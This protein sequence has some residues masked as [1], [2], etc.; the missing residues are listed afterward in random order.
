ME[1]TIC[2]AIPGWENKGYKYLAPG[3]GRWTFHNIKIVRE[4]ARQGPQAAKRDTVLVWE[5]LTGTGTVD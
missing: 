4:D 3:R 1:R 5:P 2:D